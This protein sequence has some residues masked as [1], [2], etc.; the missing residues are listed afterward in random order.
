M[1]LAVFCCLNPFTSLQDQESVSGLLS[2]KQKKK[3]NRWGE[4][5]DNVELPSITLYLCLPV[6]ASMA[7]LPPSMSPSLLIFFPGRCHKEMR[8]AER[9]KEKRHRTHLCVEGGRRGRKRKKTW[10]RT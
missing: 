4:L 8:K 9:E 5:R 1:E 3:K 2:I 6:F 10:E 7:A